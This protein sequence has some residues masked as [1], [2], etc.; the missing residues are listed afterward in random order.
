MIEVQN[1]V[2]NFVSQRNFWGKTTQWVHAV[3][4]VSFSIP[5][6]QTLS[7]VGE[8]GSGKSTTGRA[9]LRLIQATSGNILINGTDISSLNA[10]KMHDL[11]KKIQIVFQDPYSS[12][13]PRMSIYSILAEPFQIHKKK[14]LLK[15]KQLRDNLVQL[16]EQVGLEP[17]HLYRFPHE[18]S[19]GQRQRIGIARAIALDPDFLVLDE[20]VSALDLSV[21]AQ[22]I[23][24]LQDIKKQ[25]QLTYLFIA[26][27]LSVVHY[28]SDFT[29]VMYLG[30]IVEYQKT[31][32][33]FTNPAHPYSQA[34]VAS[35]P[36]THP[37]N[38][39][40]QSLSGEIPSPISPPSGCSFHP[41]CF[42]AKSICSQEVPPTVARQ[43]GWLTCH[44]PS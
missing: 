34:L 38:K 40:A 6:G 25:R 31:N 10:R 24:L 12:L 35:L 5:K 22:I 11:R 20:P 18:F 27:D 44:F 8:S 4:N 37:D 13:N 42:K 32:T 26:H 19:G 41:R 33:L 23:N 14:I 16:L 2:K 36:R 7:L 17:Y 15:K 21:Q 30:Q 29:A 43:N 9:I 3:R 28:I 1:L 39:P